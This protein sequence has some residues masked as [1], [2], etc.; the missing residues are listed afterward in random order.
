MTSWMERSFVDPMQEVIMFAGGEHEGHGPRALSLLLRV[1]E[2]ARRAQLTK[3]WP[4]RPEKGADERW[5][6]GRVEEP[7]SSDAM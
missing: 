2:Y 1:V 4:S 3:G 6:S 7:A 5:W